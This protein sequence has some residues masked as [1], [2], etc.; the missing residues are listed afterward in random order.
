MHRGTDRISSSGFRE[1]TCLPSL[2]R[3]QVSVP[4]HRKILGV[5]DEIYVRLDD[6]L[7]AKPNIWCCS[8]GL[9]VITSFE[10]PTVL[11]KVGHNVHKSATNRVLLS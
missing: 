7:L 3:T 10:M 2:V 1:I 9:V 6:L 8:A 4:S 5:A 11:E